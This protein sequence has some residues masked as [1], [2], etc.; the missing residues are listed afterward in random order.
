MAQEN[1][2]EMEDVLKA[3]YEKESEAKGKY[4]EDVK[5]LYESVQKG[6][7]SK[8]DHLCNALSEFL[9]AGDE[10]SLG[11]NVSLEGKDTE[12]VFV[13]LN[14]ILSMENAPLGKWPGKD[15]LKLWQQVDVNLALQ[16]SRDGAFE[17]V[18]KI[19]A[20]KEKTDAE[21]EAVLKE[22]LADRV[23]EKANLM[24]NYDK[25]DDAFESFVFYHGEEKNHAYAE[26]PAKWHRIREDQFSECGLLM[27]AATDAPIRKL[28]K[29][30]EAQ[31]KTMGLLAA[32]ISDDAQKKQF[33]EK[34]L[35]PMIKAYREDD[36]AKERL[37]K[38]LK[39]REEFLAQK[40]V[41]TDMLAH[42]SQLS[43]ELFKNWQE[44]KLHLKDLKVA[45]AEIEHSKK[46]A[47]AAEASRNPLRDQ[48]DKAVEAMNEF[49]SK[50]E[51]LG[52][53]A[54]AA[55]I[56]WSR[57]NDII[58]T[59][60]DKEQE[61]RGSVNAMTK[62]LSKK[63][64]DSVMEEADKYQ[65]EAIEAQEKA[66]AAEKKMKELAAQ[67]D[68]L[69]SQREKLQKDQDVV[70]EKLAQINKT[71]NSAR[72]VMAKR[73]EEAEQIR[74]A[75]NSVRKERETILE[76]YSKESGEDQ[77]VL[78]DVDFVQD[79]LSEDRKVREAREAQNP[80]FSQKYQKEREKLFTAALALTKAFVEASGC[81]ME[82]LATLSQYWG[83]WKKGNE[84]ITFH[85]ADL[86]DTVPSLWQT[87]F[88]MLPLVELELGGVAETLRDAKK[89][90]LTGMMVV[91]CEGKLSPVKILGAI[92]RCRKVVS[93]K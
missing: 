54:Q 91:D 46:D 77:R 55:K 16:K 78:L 11:N 53:A 20:A 49:L 75:L 51:E 81:C 7:Y 10:A 2:M 29:D 17:E 14:Q 22:L 79:L 60:F 27:T 13:M 89:P 65:K 82:N 84:K 67:Y 58:R 5:Y 9:E 36:P 52:A 39:A 4:L 18:G 68:E 57:N 15:G 63:K 62:L 41:V 87:L 28:C 3:L 8:R 69:A 70:T 85:Q 80:W 93:L 90:G 24:A 59:G 86:D 32:S 23:V 92:Y 40:K 26:Y 42:L 50:L 61:L 71:V 19:I 47:E 72:Q 31:E 38:Y 33:Y 45:E 34:V 83:F 74:H 56:E 30:L 88:M 48:R 21:K 73:E 44:E 12:A 6:T 76:I 64:Y 1:K 66:P 43:K 35:A 37:P 25:P